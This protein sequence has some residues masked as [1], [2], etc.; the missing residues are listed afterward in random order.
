M[1]IR[2]IIFL[3]KT[4]EIFLK[5]AMRENKLKRFELF[6][7]H[8]EIIIKPE[9]VVYANKQPRPIQLI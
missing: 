2:K 5:L 4:I 1:H 8:P 3:L 7:I 6:N 9:G